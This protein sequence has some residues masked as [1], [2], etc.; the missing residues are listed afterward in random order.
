MKVLYEIYREEEN[1]PCVVFCKPEM[2]D[3][4]LYSVGK[5]E[6]DMVDLTNSFNPYRNQGKRFENIYIKNID[7]YD[8]YSL[9]VLLSCMSRNTNLLATV[10]STK[11]N[12][13][14]IRKLLVELTKLPNREGYYVQLNKQP[15]VRDSESWFKK[16]TPDLVYLTMLS[17]GERF[18]VP[19][20]KVV[21][22]NTEE[23]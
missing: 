9:L 6:R 21:L 19:P 23:V 12:N 5:S 14:F 15:L 11:D 3:D 10:S 17:S 20:V 18:Y 2:F 1:N 4:F 7:L 13:P 8:E 22:L 16:N